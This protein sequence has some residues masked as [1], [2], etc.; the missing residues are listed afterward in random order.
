M[1][2]SLDRSNFHAMLLETPQ[3]FAAGLSIAR[4]IRVP[5]TYRSVMISGMGGSALPGDL[6]RTYLRDLSRRTGAAHEPLL[7]HDNRTYQLPDAGRHECLHFIASYSG[8][9]EETIASFEEVLAQNLSCVVLSSGGKLEALAQERGVPHIKLPIPFP[10]FQP[11]IGTGYFFGAMLQ[12]LI[13]Q[14]LVPD[15]TAEL[16]RENEVLR[17]DLPV[18]DEHGQALARRFVGKTPVIYASSQ[19]GSVAMVWKIK[20]NENAKTPAATGK[21]YRPHAS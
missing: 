8:N 3:Q 10:E 19:F 5:G 11:R 1:P 18:I 17:H 9:T 16:L 13:N 7:V 20:L 14:G 6:F 21:V 4:D 12:V 15:E 2:S